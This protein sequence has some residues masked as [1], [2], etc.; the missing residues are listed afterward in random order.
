MQPAFSDATGANLAAPSGSA[1]LGPVGQTRSLGTVNAG[2]MSSKVVPNN[3][4]SPVRE[5]WSA[6]TAP[7]ELGSKHSSRKPHVALLE[8]CSGQTPTQI[9][10][11]QAGFC[12]HR[13]RTA[14][15]AWPSPGR[16]RSNS[17]EGGPTAP[18]RPMLARNRI[19]LARIWPTFQ[20]KSADFV[21]KIGPACVDAHSGGLQPAPPHPGGLPQLPRLEQTR[22]RNQEWDAGTPST[23]R[24][25]MGVAPS[26]SREAD[27]VLGDGAVVDDA[28]TVR[29][30]G[31]HERRRRPHGARAHFCLRARPLRHFL[32]NRFRS[33]RS[34]RVNA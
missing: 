26:L 20:P 10:V 23:S 27:L 16:N 13:A 22:P 12:P 2:S 33:L 32:G 6:P 31:I 19:S 28:L 30:D 11:A 4:P 9:I 1:T 24:S 15:I 18:N 7:W 14:P 5:S 34:A 29:S 8:S 3:C 21:Q 25:R 17:V